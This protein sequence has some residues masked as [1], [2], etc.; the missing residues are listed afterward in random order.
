MRR[1]EGTLASPSPS[2]SSHERLSPPAR[3]TQASP[4]HSTPLPPLRVCLPFPPDNLPLYQLRNAGTVSRRQHRRCGTHSPTHAAI[5]KAQSIHL[6]RFIN[7]TPIDQ[8][9]TPHGAAN[10]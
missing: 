6:L 10:L 8:H 2:S 4:L 7:V 3:A 5:D 9:W 1:G